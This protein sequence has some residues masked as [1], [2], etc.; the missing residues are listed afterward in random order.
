MSKGFASSYRI[1]ILASGLF[2]C[3]GG[4][5]TRLVWLH[6]VDRDSL[7]KTVTKVRQQTITEFARRGDIVDRNGALLATS[8]SRR[9]LGVDPTALRPQDEKLWPQLAALIHL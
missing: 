7:L 6:V 1:V 2:V 9:V 3:F 8:S 4:V 5:G